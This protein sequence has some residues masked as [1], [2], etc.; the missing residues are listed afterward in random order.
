MSLSENGERVAFLAAL[1]TVY[2]DYEVYWR[3]GLADQVSFPLSMSRDGS[4][5]SWKVRRP[6]RAD[7]TRALV[8]TDG[9]EGPAF[10]DCGLPVV[11]A[12]G[13]TVAYKACEREDS[14]FIVRNGRR[15]G[16]PAEGITNPALSDDGSVLA[17]A[18]EAADRYRL[19]VGGREI[20][21]REMPRSV[22]LSPNGSA[23]G[24]VTQSSVITAR[25][26]SE[27]F[28]EI[29]NPAFSPDGK[30]VAFAARRGKEWTL[31]VGR[32]G[33][34]MPAPIAGPVW[35][36]DGTQLGYGALQGREIWWRVVG[37]P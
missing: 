31:Q 7:E 37:V 9:V 35:S 25:G 29:V 27:E 8:V 1:N 26:R 3:G 36:R 12:D 21:L 16:A 19:I 33:L 4:V 30:R 10:G 34:R 11:S 18:T 24:Y 6:L 14:W 20:E 15:V 28:D 2:R 17:Y 23:W 5:L 22:F 13:R 32:T